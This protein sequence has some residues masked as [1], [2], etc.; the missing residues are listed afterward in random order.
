M[1]ELTLDEPIAGGCSADKDVVEGLMSQGWF[2]SGRETCTYW[3]LR[4]DDPYSGGYYDSNCD[5]IPDGD[6]THNTVCYHSNITI[7]FTS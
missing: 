3:I 7:A 4:G 5:N 6:Q 1:E 2:N